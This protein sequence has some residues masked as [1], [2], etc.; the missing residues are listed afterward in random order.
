MG[1]E[2]DAQVSP[3]PNQDD[4][5]EQLPEQARRERSRSRDAIRSYI[6]LIKDV[7]QESV[8][9][10]ER[11]NQQPTAEGVAGV[12][13]A[14]PSSSSSSPA[15]TT[16]GGSVVDKAST[17][18]SVSR[19]TSLQSGSSAQV[20][21][22]STL[23]SIQKPTPATKSTTDVEDRASMRGRI[24]AYLQNKGGKCREMEVMTAM[25]YVD[26]TGTAAH[27]EFVKVLREMTTLEKPNVVLKDKYRN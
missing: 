16:E 22:K 21:T 10:S 26:K 18:D 5:V 2:H 17:G 7:A 1:K 13:E 20:V 23:P 27:K 12:D 4:E 19:T 15:A 14:K 6:G 8:S 9:S 11:S 25:G 3:S 24:V